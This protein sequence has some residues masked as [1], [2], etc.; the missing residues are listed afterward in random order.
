VST[1][2]TYLGAARAE[3]FANPMLSPGSHDFGKPP[4]PGDDEFAYGGKWRITLDSATALAGASLELNFGARRVYLV[5]G[6][7]DGRPHRMKVLLDGR[8]IADALAGADVHGGS[9]TVDAHRLY[10]LVDLPAVERHLLTLV[11]EG[12]VSGYAFTFG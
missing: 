3:R 10:D 4:A 5:L 9:V 8:P 11:P 12:G 7:D 6:T 2:E 1:P